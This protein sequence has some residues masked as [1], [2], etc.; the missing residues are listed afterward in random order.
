MVIATFI[1]RTV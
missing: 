1:I